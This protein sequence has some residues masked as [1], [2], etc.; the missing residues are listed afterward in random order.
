ML[1]ACLALLGFASPSR[2]SAW[3][4]FVIN[5]R[6]DD[7]SLSCYLGGNGTWVCAPDRLL[8]RDALPDDSY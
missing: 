7:P 4:W 8:S 5:V 3:P 1:G 2:F 6:P